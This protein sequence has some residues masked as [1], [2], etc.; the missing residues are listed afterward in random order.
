MLS[1]A[2]KSIETCCKWE[3]RTR[4]PST[5]H[6]HVTHTST[7]HVVS[8][9]DTTSIAQTPWPVKTIICPLCSTQSRTFRFNNVPSPKP[10]SCSRVRPQ[11]PIDSSSVG[12]HEIL[13]EVK[14]TGGPSVILAIRRRLTRF[15]LGICGSDVC[16]QSCLV[17]VPDRDLT[18][19]HLRFIFINMVESALLLS[20]SLWCRISPY[21]RNVTQLIYSLSGSWPRVLGGG[22]S[23][24]II[25]VCIVQNSI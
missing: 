10:V 25:L 6:T 21:E 11:C 18:A 4:A 12:D 5:R 7:C 24:L 15:D 14:K 8:H 20:R 19:E 13:V 17:T 2:Q 23:R 16:F 1:P 3:V 9:V 22:H